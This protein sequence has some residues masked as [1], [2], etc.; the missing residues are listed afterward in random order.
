MG[1]NGFPPGRLCFYV[2]PDGIGADMGAGC[3]DSMG[4]G[5]IDRP[6]WVIY[7]GARPSKNTVFHGIFGSC[8]ISRAANCGRGVTCKS[9]A[10]P[11]PFW[12]HACVPSTS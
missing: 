12:T 2:C 7:H 10:P 8:S 5:R 4:R 9:H 1:G 3:A 11:T 6:R